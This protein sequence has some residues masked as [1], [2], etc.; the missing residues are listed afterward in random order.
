MKQRIRVVGIIRNSDGVLV[1]KRNR[2]RSEAPVFWELP[3]GKI[4]FGEQ[5]EEAM[6]RSLAENVGLSATSLKLKDVVTFMALEGSSQLS[7]LYIVYEVQVPDGAKP[8]PRDRYTAYKFLRDP[9]A[10]GVKLNEATMM[11]FE[12]EN[13]HISINKVSPRDTANSATVYVDG[14]SRGNPGPSGVG[15]VVVSE[16]GE[17]LKQGGEFIG[18]ATSRVAEYYA[19]EEGMKV[20]IDM[21]LKSVRFVTD[22]L[23]VANQMN[24]IFQIKNQDILPIYEDVQKLLD[25][26]EVVAFSHVPRSQNAAADREANLAID[27]MLKN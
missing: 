15:Y 26:F 18:F 22:S 4:S 19:L 25:D 16:T 7:N 10:A 8:D 3:T 24:G 20:A 11:V 21:G 9:I 6:V 12:I 2:G 27:Q 17:V 1:L 5:P 13:G 14:A 23:M